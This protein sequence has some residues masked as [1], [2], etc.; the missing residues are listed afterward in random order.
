[1][2][3]QWTK[4]TQ[5]FKH[6]WRPASQ[7]DR[8][9]RLAPRGQTSTRRALPNCLLQSRDRPDLPTTPQ[10]RPSRWKSLRS[11]SPRPD[12]QATQLPHPR[13]HP[14]GS[15]RRSALCGPVPQRE[16]YGVPRHVLPDGLAGHPQQNE[17]SLILH[18]P[19]LS[20]RPVLPRIELAPVRAFPL[21]STTVRFLASPPSRLM[22]NCV[23]GYTWYSWERPVGGS[24]TVHSGA[25]GGRIGRALPWR[26]RFWRAW[27]RSGS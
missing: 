12:A 4:E 19:P 13:H 8:A 10:L 2:F 20:G 3:W 11:Q 9:K 23:V 6:F 7:P 14:L 18:H 17:T 22:A 5:D 21:A 25:L 1:M 15:P 27:P 16:P 26:R 24:P